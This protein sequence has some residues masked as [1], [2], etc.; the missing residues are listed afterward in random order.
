[1]IYFMEIIVVF[2]KSDT[3]VSSIQGLLNAEIQLDVSLIDN[4]LGEMKILVSTE[5]TATKS[6]V[7]FHQE[8]KD[9]VYVPTEF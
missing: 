5:E 6:F 1:M 4:K 9:E 2:S 3:V 8:D 7:K